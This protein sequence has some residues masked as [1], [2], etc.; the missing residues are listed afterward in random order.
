MH[1]FDAGCFARPLVGA[2]GAPLETGE[3]ADC[4]L[5]EILQPWRPCGLGRVQIPAQGG[6]RAC[7]VCQVGE[8][9]AGCDGADGWFY[10]MDDPDCAAGT[11]AFT[12]GAEPLEG[13]PFRFGCG[14]G[15]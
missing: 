2:N 7:H 14:R 15:C 9:H 3:H 11:I 13:T 4:E 5:V 10:S 1:P 12:P 8:A 6:M